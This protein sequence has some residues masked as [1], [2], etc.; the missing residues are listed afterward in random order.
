MELKNT[1]YKME[2][3]KYFGKLSDII[4][5][6]LQSKYIKFLPKELKK[7]SRNIV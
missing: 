2:N 6:D 7:Y 4:I 5:K 1:N 3:K